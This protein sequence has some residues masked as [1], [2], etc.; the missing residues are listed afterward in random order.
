MCIEPVTSDSQAR[1][2]LNMMGLAVPSDVVRS[3]EFRTCTALSAVD[4][5]TSECDD[6]VSAISAISTTSEQLHTAHT[7]DIRRVS[8]VHTHN[9]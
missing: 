6:A 7:R 1:R 3:R 5:G 2:N 9:Q 4:S 8:G